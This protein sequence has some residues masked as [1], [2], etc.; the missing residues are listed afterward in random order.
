MKRIVLISILALLLMGTVGAAS[1]YYHYHP[2]E[3][4]VKTTDLTEYLDDVSLDNSTTISWPTDMEPG[5]S[6]TKNYTIVNTGT[7]VV[8]VRLQISGLPSG[9][10]ITW[11]ANN[12]ALN[13]GEAAIGDLT[14]TVGAGATDG[15]YYWDHIIEA[16]K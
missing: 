11:A 13:P 1:I 8:S 3:G 15:T 5:E 12:T 14:L 9:W 10:G 2:S 6:Y 7:T 4:T 16:I